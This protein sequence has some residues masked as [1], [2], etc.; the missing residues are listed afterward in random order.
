MG[1]YEKMN[2]VISYLH[3]AIT[4]AGEYLA[5]AAKRKG[6]NVIT[7]GPYFGTEMPY[8]T[9]GGM[10][11]SKEYDNKPDIIVSKTD[12]APIW[13]I[14]NKLD[15][16]VDVWLDVDAGFCLDGTPK[17]GKHIR[18]LTDPHVL[19]NRYDSRPNYDITFC[20]QKRYM[21]GGEVYLPYGYDKIWHS[22]MDVEKTY[23]VALVGNIYNHRVELFNNLKHL[24]TFFKVGIA[25]EDMRRIY[26]QAYIG[27]N[28]ST[29]DDMNARVFEIMACGICPVMNEVTDM[30]GFLVPDEDYIKFDNQSDAI[31]KINY[32]LEHKD[33]L[34]QIAKNAKDK[35]NGHSWD[36]RLQSILERTL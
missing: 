10:K 12:S 25:K 35:M 32:L 15:I 28:W 4:A 7:V 17:H 21:R 24:R 30:K 3:Y 34:E 5:R 36:D 6:L 16:P 14:E 2:I 26:N 18:F 23:D 8:G 11:V 9:D 29:L 13:F 33:K 20:S 19:R 27:L 22:P 1:I 31:Q